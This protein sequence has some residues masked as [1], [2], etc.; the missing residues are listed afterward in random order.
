VP[1]I[2]LSSSDESQKLNEASGG[3]AQCHMRKFPSVTELR[4]IITEAQR[5]SADRSTP[6]PFHLSS[7]LRFS[8]LNAPSRAALA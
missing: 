5:Y 8:A 6:A 4:D 2:M 7:N 3:G 1:V